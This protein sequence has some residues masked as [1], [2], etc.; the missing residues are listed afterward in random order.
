VQW[1]ITAKNPTGLPHSEGLAWHGSDQTF[2]AINAEGGAIRRELTP[3][4]LSVQGVRAKGPEAGQ[5][6]IC[7]ILGASVEELHR[8]LRPDVFVALKDAERSSALAE[9]LDLRVPGEELEARVKALKP[10][11]VLE[12]WKEAYGSLDFSDIDGANAALTK[13][14]RSR[15]KQLAEAKT[16]LADMVKAEAAGRSPAAVQPPDPAEWDYL[17][18]EVAELN[19]RLGQAQSNNSRRRRMELALEHFQQ[20][21]E[22]LTQERFEEAKE[23]VRNCDFAIENLKSSLSECAPVPCKACRQTLPD[24]NVAR[25]RKELVTVEGEK[26]KLLDTLFQDEKLRNLMAEIAEVPYVDEVPIRDRISALNDRWDK[27]Q[28]QKSDADKWDSWAS[29]KSEIAQKVD[30]LTAKVEALEELVKLTGEKGLKL[31]CTRRRLEPVAEQLSAILQN[32]DMSARFNGSSL[33]IGKGVFFLWTPLSQC[34]DGE[35]ILVALAIQVWLAQQSNLRLLIMDRLEALDR[36]NMCDLYHA[37][38]SLLEAEEIDGAIL[39]GVGLNESVF[40]AINLAKIKNEMEL[41][42]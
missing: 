8:A 7:S 23:L 26:S 42:K 6:K 29:R 17:R 32:W 30:W 35:T 10:L 4:A 37:V 25:I 12:A 39:A 21:R 27:V 24:P 31:E 18:S 38:M 5:S 13:E 40:G 36:Q 9:I 34:S 33:E 1:C 14:R 28:I 41:S 19:L 16:V 11:P 22:P 15:K 3:H 2:V 20:L